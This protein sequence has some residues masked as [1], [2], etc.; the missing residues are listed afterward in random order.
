MKRQNVGQL[1]SFCKTLVRTLGSHFFSL[2]QLQ[3]KWRC[4]GAN[5]LN[6]DLQT[7]SHSLHHAPR[8][9]PTSRCFS[10]ARL[11]MKISPSIAQ[12]PLHLLILFTSPSQLFAQ[13]TWTQFSESFFLYL[14]NGPGGCDRP[15]PNGIGM[16]D[17]V[18][19]SLND[20]WTVSDTVVEELPTSVFSY[21]R[22]TRGLLFLLFGVTWTVYYEPNPN[23]GSEADYNYI[24]GIFQHHIISSLPVA[25]D[26][27][28]LLPR[29][30]N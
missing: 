21:N 28:T 1:F 12:M 26:S 23:D 16:N 4:Q 18:L 19:T 9:L 10:H 24:L 27:Q 30:A 3:G 22:E 15:A 6:D 2:V 14:G 13:V 25:D 29:L 7:D 8:S 20:A 17:Y 5:F 11:T